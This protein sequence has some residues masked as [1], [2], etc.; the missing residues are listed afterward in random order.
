MTIG[1]MADAAV[2]DSTADATVVSLLKGL[3][4]AGGDV[5]DVTLSLD[6]NAY[7]SGDVLAATQEVASAV[8]ANGGKALLTSLTVLD[9]DDQAGAFEVV[10]LRSNVPLGTE[11]DAVGISDANAAEV[12]GIVAVAAANYFDL[13]GCQV[14]QP[15]ITAPIVLEA[16]AASTSIFI[17]AV[18]RDTKTYTAAGLVL[19]LGLVYL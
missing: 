8:R 7:V 19:K 13:G 16:A 2:V 3:M 18:S 10:F 11:N 17:G 9:K 6:T 1:T 15:A 4:S 5:V 14:A 12:L